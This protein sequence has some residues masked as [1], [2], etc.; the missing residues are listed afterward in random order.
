MAQKIAS[1]YAEIGADTS[2]LNKG[3]ANAKGQLGNAA[4]EMD[5][6]A[7][8][9]QAMGNMVKAAALAGFGAL[10]AGVTA[11]VK[12]AAELETSFGK[13]A[14][15]TDT[16]RAAIQGLTKDVMRM[17]TEIP[18]SSHELADALY[19]ISSSG[20]QGAEA[21]DILR[22]SAKAAAAGLGETKIIAD[23]V[24]S[25][26]NAYQLSGKDAA[27]MTDILTAAVREGKGEPEEFAGSL[28]RVLPIA[29]AAGVSMEQVA[30][31]MATMTRTGLSADEA[32]TAL[33][34][35]IGA[36]LAPSKQAKDALAAMGLT[37]DELAKMIRDRG[38]MDVLKLLMERTHGNVEALDAIIPN[39]RAL[40][41]VLSTAGSQGEDYAKV[42]GVMEN[43][44]GTTDRA[45]TEMSKTFEFKLKR[46]QNSLE[47]LGIAVGQKLLPPLS[48]AADAA[49]TLINWQDKLT[50]AF[51]GTAKKIEE[52]STSY[53]DYR[54][55][56]VATAEAAGQL[57]HTQAVQ[58]LNDE[59]GA[60][61]FA[62]NKIGLFTEEQWNL[63]KAQ[64]DNIGLY[65][66]SD[67]AARN[68]A[69][70]L[71]TA[72]GSTEGLTQAAK[73]NTLAVEALKAGYAGPIRKEMD[74]YKSKQDELKTKA[75]E[76][77]AEIDKL[78]A[79]QG[80]QVTSSKSSALSAHEL[81]AAQAKLA[82]TDATLL[83]NA[84]KRGESDLALAA[85]MAGLQV[86][87]DKLTA[88][89]DGTSGATQRYVDNTKKIGELTA[90][91]DKVNA[92]IAENVAAHDEAMKRII[93]DIAQQQLATDGWTNT[94]IA[95]F[96]KVAVSMGIFDQASAD[97]TT[98]VLSATS[99]LAQDQN[100]NQFSANMNT[101]FA[102]A[103]ASADAQ[104]GYIRTRVL[105][106]DKDI[107]ED[108]NIPAFAANVSASMGNAALAT[109]PF[110][111]A[112][113]DT[114]TITA[115]QTGKITTDTQTMMSNITAGI[116]ANAP[117]AFNPL[118]NEFDDMQKKASN[119]INSIIGDINNM[120]SKISGIHINIP[121][122]SGGG[123]G[124]TGG[125]GR[126][127]TGGGAGG[128]TGRR[129]GRGRQHG[130]PVMAGM[131]QLHDYEYVLSEAMRRGRMPIPHEAWLSGTPQTNNQFN[132][133]INTSQP[134]SP[135]REFGLMQALAGAQ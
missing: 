29:A 126:G 53:T 39:V 71:D 75:A 132:L 82:L 113:I 4:G 81:A 32:A 44:A 94:E 120:L 77:R 20:F 124:G 25:A 69:V 118:K 134:A 79:T 42:L 68:M 11:S 116:A 33:R 85:R 31:S 58:I 67:R 86:Q 127:G 97:L 123:G 91:Y 102:I 2:G 119:V 51:E 83:G 111:A 36:L 55:A 7:R 99:Q 59:A 114:A 9:A 47:N 64:Q 43:A 37:T 88:K 38:L 103:S 50:E 18:V 87:H 62:A 10:V 96:T 98:N 41:G 129:G 26:L 13:I 61:E 110:K 100:I 93:L 130:G 109:E 78:S 52:T 6:T 133:T 30:A 101:A 17:S 112:V 1:L 14:A 48:D 63:A 106:A 57:T 65:D 46:A 70:G 19:F 90:E 135:I 34:G 21:M 76:L 72:K 40:T 28:G 117:G 45:F 115:E 56:I 108:Q 15:L 23:A 27:R 16:P 122:V 107:A 95:A 84:K 125:G 8:A 121:G 3:L 54:S 22:A 104:M 73:D 105:G 92:A 5:K 131:Y 35:T 66:E 49:S 60:A 24:T 89:I 12:S 80:A 128:G 74:D